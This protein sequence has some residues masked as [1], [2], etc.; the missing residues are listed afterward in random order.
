MFFTEGET[1]S[2]S[3]EQL[4]SSHR[5]SPPIYRYVLGTY[6]VLGTRPRPH[7]YLVSAFM[8]LVVGWGW[9]G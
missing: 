7:R 1:E 4:G 9:G 5:V 2:G 8:D 3:R 6:S